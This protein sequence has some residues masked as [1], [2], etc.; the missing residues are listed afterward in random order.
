MKMQ[1]RIG[2]RYNEGVSPQEDDLLSGLSEELD[3]LVT[4]LYKAFHE[5]ESD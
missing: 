3:E 2:D 1:K 4:L 5:E